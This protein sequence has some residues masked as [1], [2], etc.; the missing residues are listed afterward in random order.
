MSFLRIRFTLF[1]LMFTVSMAST[2]GCKREK[3]YG[4]RPPN[5]FP[6]TR[7][8]IHS[9]VALDS[10]KIWA[11]G[12][13]AGIYHSPDG[14]AS[15][16]PQESG[17]D[18][19][20]QLCKADFVDDQYGWIVGSFGTILHT[21]DGGKTWNTQDSTTGNLLLNVDF[22]DRQHGWAVGEKATILRT[23]DGGATWTLQFD[24]MGPVYNGVQFLDQ[25]T[26]WI[27]GDYGTILHT[28]D[29]G[30]SWTTQECQDIIPVLDEEDLLAWEPIPVLFDVAF[31]NKQKGLACGIDGLI[32]VT[33]DGGLN[34]KKISTPLKLAIYALAVNDNKVWAIGEKGNYLVSTDGGYTW[35][36]ITDV[37]KT[38][39]WLRGISFSSAT[40]GWVV[41]G[42][43]TVVKTTD[44]GD[45][46]EMVSGQSYDI[47]SV[48]D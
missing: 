35:K 39:K 23:R 21:E 29:G 37:I 13:F 10:Q 34:W 31:V 18:D 41:G 45:S 33:E 24:E 44:G 16:E 28:T 38:R 48:W 12:S 26:G 17:L 47:R 36:T 25:Q 4:Y 27:V 30:E 5:Y 46:W 1:L 14:G 3:L 40:S 20:T 8:D 19:L 7:D 22:I 6:V 9:V 15:W 43:G 42:M 2:G 32:L 11:I